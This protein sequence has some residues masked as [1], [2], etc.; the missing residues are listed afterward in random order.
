VIVLQPKPWQHLD[1]AR[2][3]MVDHLAFDE[4]DDGEIRGEDR[5]QK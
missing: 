5:S 4:L 2:E 1:G 3:E